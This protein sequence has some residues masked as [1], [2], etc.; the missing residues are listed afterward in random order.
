MTQYFPNS[1]P[2]DWL[3]REMSGNPI[4]AQTILQRFVDANHDGAISAQELIALT[5]PEANENFLN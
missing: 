5:S 2:I 4:L 3:A 1:F